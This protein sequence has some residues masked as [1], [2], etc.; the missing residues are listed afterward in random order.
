MLI[1]SGVISRHLVCGLEE[2]GFIGS[3]PGET[4][5]TECV[6]KFSYICNLTVYPIENNTYNYYQ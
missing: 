6:N 1:N 2:L 4:C 5:A 3:A